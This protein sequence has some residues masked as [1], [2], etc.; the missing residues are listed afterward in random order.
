MHIC[1]KIVK[2]QYFM[3]NHQLE[4]VKEEKDLEM[5][6]TQDLKVS[7]QCQ[8]AYN[9]APWILGLINHTI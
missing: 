3:N 5:L 6:I 4:E 2:G 9:K 1:K 8:L 7:Q